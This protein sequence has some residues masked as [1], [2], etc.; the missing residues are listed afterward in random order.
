LHQPDWSSDSHSL[1]ATVLSLT[2]VRVFHFICNAY[3]GALS[4]ELPELP[5]GADGGWRRL[6]DTALP[7]P[8]DICGESEAVLLKES[9]YLAQP[10][11]VVL[12]FANTG[13]GIKKATNQES[14]QDARN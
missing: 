6:L 7:S 5:E 10:R 14:K 3:W 1:A 13:Q 2:G 11:S 8:M 9:A 12:L 4:F